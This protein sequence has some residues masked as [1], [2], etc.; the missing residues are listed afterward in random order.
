MNIFVLHES[1]IPCAQMHCDKHVVKMIVEY[2]QL[3]ATAHRVLDG[4]RGKLLHPYSRQRVAYD[5]NW[6]LDG[7]DSKLP[8]IPLATHHNH[9]CAVWARQSSGNYWWLFF[10]WLALMREF[11]VR[12][13]HGHS[14]S[15]RYVEW[16]SNL[17]VNLPEGEQTQWPLCMPEQYQVW[18]Q[19]CCGSPQWSHTSPPE[20]CGQ[21]N[22]IPDAVASYRAYYLGEKMGFATWKKNRTAPAWVPNTRVKTTTTVRTPIGTSQTL[23]PF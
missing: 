3:L 9:P 18:H 21:L 20:C 23:M 17:P 6:V 4:H 15:T 10:L 13:G 19:E 22:S 8:F 5:Y 16:L 2:G 14:Y 11:S 1:P 12:Y 7:E